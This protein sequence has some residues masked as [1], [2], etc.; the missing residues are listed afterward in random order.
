VKTAVDS[1]ILFDLL[2]PTPEFVATSG[3]AIRAGRIGASSPLAEP[4]RPVPSPTSSSPPT[5]NWKPAAC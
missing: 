4:A 2:L 3:A 5:L 1:N